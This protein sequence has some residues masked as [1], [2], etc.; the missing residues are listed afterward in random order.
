MPVCKENSNLK[1]FKFKKKNNAIQEADNATR[2]Q[3]LTN[4]L[5]RI[6]AN[7]DYEQNLD[8]TACKKGNF[9]K[10]IR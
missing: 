10:I 5:D 6:D 8:A 7:S 1:T 9:A 3:T 4:K 2:F